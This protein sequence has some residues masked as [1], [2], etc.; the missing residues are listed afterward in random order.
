MWATAYSMT[1]T[2]LYD[3][4]DPS[5]LDFALLR[6]WFRKRPHTVY[7]FF[8]EYRM[9]Q[10]IVQESDADRQNGLVEG[11][12]FRYGLHLSHSPRLNLVAFYVQIPVRKCHTAAVIFDYAN[13]K[14][15]FLGAFPTIMG[16]SDK[17]PLA[18]PG[19]ETPDYALLWDIL[20][21]AF[22]TLRDSGRPWSEVEKVFANQK[23]VC[24]LRM[25]ALP[26][27]SPYFF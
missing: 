1:P 26:Y 11:L 16:P 9:I 15:F 24:L 8:V 19:W 21:G 25:L 27:H 22:A 6:F 3:L 20:R 5:L 18:T 2:V 17:D 4:T 12:E 13:S 10:L 7:A 14:A 23:E